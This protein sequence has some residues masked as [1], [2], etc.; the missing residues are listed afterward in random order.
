MNIHVSRFLVGLPCG[1]LVLA[2]SAARGADAPAASTT[3]P[4]APAVATAA[5]PGSG[6]YHALKTIPVGGEGSFDY[7]TADPAAHRLYVSHGNV[8]MVLDTEKEAV[9]GQ[10]DDTVGVHGIAIAPKLNR[11]YT[12]NGGA[13]EVSVVDLATL[14]TLSKVGTGRNPDAI[15][16]EPSQ[17]EVWAFNHSGQSTTVFA[18]DTGKVVA[19]VPLNGAVETGVADSEAH[20][21]YINL[22]DKNEVAVV[23]MKTHDVVARWPIAPGEGGTGLAIDV[24]HHLIFVGCGGN[25]K[26]VAL[27]TTT[28][29][30]V[31]NVPAGTGIDAAAFD[32]ASGLVFASAGDGTV[33]IAHEDAPDK[34]TVVQ[35]LKTEPRA[36]T[37]ALDPVTHKIYLSTATYPAAAAGARGRPAA[38]PGSFHVL[39]YGTEAADKKP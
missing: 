15:L 14:K 13:N 31:A 23:D 6:P 32:P 11:G 29:K 12:S 18:A 38:V 39:V 37:M 4:A 22:E 26:I 33:T 28:G 34:L 8:V 2:A 1:L 21:V 30:V 25:A 35:N 20:R 17:N 36:K 3:K 10:I 27:D 9:V 16:F 19:T 5:A 7:L 24:A